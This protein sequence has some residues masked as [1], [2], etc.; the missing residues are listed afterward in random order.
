MIR[1]PEQAGFEFFYS[2]AESARA[3][4]SNANRWASLTLLLDTNHGRE[5]LLNRRRFLRR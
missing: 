1:P 3:G 2:Q 4:T 5:E